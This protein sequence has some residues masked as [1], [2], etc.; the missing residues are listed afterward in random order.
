MKAIKKK[1]GGVKGTKSVSKK[2]D[3]IENNENSPISELN[4]HSDQ[5]KKTSLKSIKTFSNTKENYTNFNDS[6]SRQTNKSISNINESSNEHPSSESKRKSKNKKSL[7]NSIS[8][9]SSKITS[10]FK[11][12]KSKSTKTKEKNASITD[13]YIM[14]PWYYDCHSDTFPQSGM[15]PLYLATT[16]CTP[17]FYNKSMKYHFDTYTRNR[18]KNDQQCMFS[19]K[20]VLNS[21]AKSY[22]NFRQLYSKS[23]IKNLNFYLKNVGLMLKNIEKVKK[24]EL[25]SSIGYSQ[26][27]RL[28]RFVLSSRN[29]I[30]KDLSRIDKIYKTIINEITCNRK[31]D[32]EYGE[33]T[34]KEFRMLP[35]SITA[36]SFKIILKFNEFFSVYNNW[37]PGC[38][39]GKIHNYIEDLTKSL[40]LL[41]L[42]LGNF[43]KYVSCNDICLISNISNDARNKPVSQI[44][45]NW[46]RSVSSS[47][48]ISLYSSRDERKILK[49]KSKYS[50]S[51]CS[52]NTSD[53]F[54]NKT[55]LKRIK[56]IINK[57]I[58]LW[59]STS[60]TDS[61]KSN[62]IVEQIK[63]VIESTSNSDSSRKS[64][65]KIRTI[66]KACISKNLKNISSQ[67]KN[68]QDSSLKKNLGSKCYKKRRKITFEVSSSDN[69]SIQTKSN[70]SCKKKIKMKKLSVYYS[71]H[72][73]SSDELLSKRS[74]WISDSYYQ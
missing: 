60:Y 41:H 26:I 47:S 70:R 21:F 25:S 59:S 39:P 13:S 23:S 65:R 40:K 73:D 16:N 31:K 44:K 6:K 10:S 64:R 55:K 1:P 37:L 2:I 38:S 14:P 46:Y 45:S 8:Q 57:D 36:L 52:T 24:N 20:E 43:H 9:L 30:A 19:E 4:L 48:M 49:Q 62:M 71:I 3:H 32:C 5:T 67:S 54:K 69:T 34:N 56:N 63:S 28:E 74:N 11:R 58:H 35:V 51:K 29:Q 15:Y 68:K 50:V 66:N 27:N 22:K 7:L 18:N 53:I 61:H 72:T 12:S 42:E 33:I 17:E